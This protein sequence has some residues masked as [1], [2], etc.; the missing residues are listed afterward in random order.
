MWGGVDG[1]GDATKMSF[2][3]PEYA[4]SV[5]FSLSKHPEANLFNM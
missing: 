2:I 5:Y 4:A 3:E 1:H